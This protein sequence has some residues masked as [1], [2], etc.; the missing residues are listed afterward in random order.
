LLGLHQ[1][2]SLLLLESLKDP[3]TH[4]AKTLLHPESGRMVSLSDI[5]RL[6][7]WHGEH[8]LAQMRYAL[9]L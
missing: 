6:Y 2:W 3:A 8:H 1:K 4:L 7:A 5:I 9:S